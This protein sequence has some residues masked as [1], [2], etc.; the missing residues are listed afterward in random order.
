MAAAERPAPVGPAPRVPRG[1]AWWVLPGLACLVAACAPLVREPAPRWVA[2]GESGCGAL[3]A[4]F[5]AQVARDGV[6]DAQTTAVPGFPYL[7][8]DRFAQSFAR[9]PDPA[10]TRRLALWGYLRE[11]DR[12]ARRAESSNLSDDGWMRLGTNR[13]EGDAA[14]RRCADGMAAAAVGDATAVAAALS[15]VSVPDDYSDAA[16]AFGLYPLTRLAF[17]SG[18]RRWQ[19]ESI[20][21]FAAPRGGD[22]PRYEPLVSSPAAPSEVRAWLAPAARDPLG[23]ITLADN[24]VARLFERYA[25]VFAMIGTAPYD[26]IGAVRWQER[27][28]PGVDVD[29]PVV[30]RRLAYTRYRGA[31][32][33]QLVYTAWFSERP[34]RAG[35]DPLAGRLD[36]TIFRV[37]LG[38][39]GEVVMADAIH[40][41]GCWHLFFPPTG[42]R[43]LPAPRPREE[44]A[45]SPSMLPALAAG[46]RIALDL[47]SGTHMVVG[48]RAVDVG[49]GTTGYALEDE[50]HLRSLPWPGGG[51]RSLYGPDGLV[52]ASRRPE[53]LLFWPMGISSA[54]TMR[55]WGHHATAFVG[56]RHFDDADLLDRRFDLVP[57]PASP[58]PPRGP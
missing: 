18:I 52:A 4:R 20:A 26:R 8:A 27:Q 56:R 53:R 17:A 32:L 50:D 34:P 5:D 21:S 47:E 40:P 23:R 35:L 11:L 24:D 31:T 39:A 2:A 44:W 46:Q 43:A 55:Q 49:A 38:P 42:T 6:R 22:G 30:Y 14:V 13:P 16:R 29:R 45:F 9:E 15:R 36:G 10:G 28:E 37:T 58:P 3:V 48:I 57:D 1:R 19:R 41:C 7:R 33:V 25:P 12:D 54:G 51:R